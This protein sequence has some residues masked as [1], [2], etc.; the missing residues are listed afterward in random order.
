MKNFFDKFY[1]SVWGRLA[2]RFV[3]VG[4]S[5]VIAWMV[6]T[7]KLVLTPDGLVNSVLTWD[8][9]VLVEA[10]KLFIGAGFLAAVDKAR[11]EGTW[12]WLTEEEKAA[13]IPAPAVDAGV[14]EK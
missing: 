13:R 3:V 14:G 7:G 11:R 1:A 5:A 9:S 4:L 12:N 2:R 10:I 6:S 8:L